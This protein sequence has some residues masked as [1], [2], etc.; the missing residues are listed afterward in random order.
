[1]R[2]FQ[3]P[4]AGLSMAALVALGG[5]AAADEAQSRGRIEQRLE[6]A[7]L[8]SDVAVTVKGDTATLTGVVS[9]LDAKNRAE[10]LARK[11]V[12]DVDNQVRVWVEP[13]EPKDVERDV[14]KAILS[15]VHLTVFDDIRFE[16]TNGGVRLVGSV[17]QPY[18]KK[19][20]AA[21]V[22]RV[23]GIA[24]IQND[25]EVQP[26]SLFDDELRA[27][28]FNRIYRSGRFV[29]YAIQVNPPVRIVVN[30]GRITL[31]GVVDSRVD[32]VQLGMI[33]RETMA[34]GV[35]NQLVVEGEREK[36]QPKPAKGASQV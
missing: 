31:S 1:M 6:G 33:A 17:H 34:F 4:L 19:D 35:D 21:R 24:S 28:L 30:R 26:V 2:R 20:I 32:Q 9:T 15:Y 3:G 27:Q 5:S 13:R 10:K 23:S 8:S 18:R 29:N 16:L 11:E 7:K 22:A 14:R 25:L 36:E 12:R